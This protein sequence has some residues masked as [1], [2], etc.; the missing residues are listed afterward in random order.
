MITAFLAT[1]EVASGLLHSGALVERWERPSALAGFPVSGL[2]GH[3]LHSTVLVTERW[4]SAPAPVEC[5]PMDAAGYYLANTA[6]DPDLDGEVPRR[7]RDMGQRAAAAG[8]AELVAEYDAGRAR[9]AALLPTL[10]GDR[11]VAQT[12]ASGL[13]VLP[14]DQCLLTRLIELTV[15]I[16]DLAVS[17][18]LPTP[19]VP[20]EAA[21]AV[22]T[23]LTRMALG[24]HGFLP[25]LRALSRRERATT[26]IAAF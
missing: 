18:D 10:P 15:H 19:D 23:C 12:G 6:P 22:A 11:L 24:S 25:V 8:P 9:L 17:L 3:L 7:I 5:D 21:E 4:V 26:S 16:D 20:A 2:A 13:R 14:L 1:A